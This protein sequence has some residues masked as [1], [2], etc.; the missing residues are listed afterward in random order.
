MEIKISVIIPTYRRPSLL[1]RCIE[2]LLEQNFDKNKYEVIVVSDGP[3]ESTHEVLKSYR[4]WGIQY[5]FHNKKK[6]PAAARN[7]GWLKAKGTLTAFTD[8]DCIPDKNWLRDIWKE[9][10]NEEEIVF[11]GTVKVPISQNPTDYELNIYNL[12]TAEFI[13]ANCICTK[14]ALLKT[15]GFDERFTAAWREDSDLHFKLL[16]LGIPIRKI[17]ALVIHPVRQAPWGIS[18]KEQKKGMFNA[19]LYKKYPHLYRERI[20]PAPS[21]NYYLM[22]LGFIVAVIGLFLESGL[23]AIAGTALWFFLLFRFIQKRLSAASLDAR[24][25]SEMVFT[26]IFIPFLSIYWQWYGAWKYRVLF[27]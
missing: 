2:A 7:L 24:H 27:L 20:K 15:G 25:V 9:Y 10:N 21:W 6:G 26:S 17:D 13:T 14:K 22:I 16:E 11:T 18:M 4:A 3:D 19:L 23:L 12:E 1:K 8:D 5:L